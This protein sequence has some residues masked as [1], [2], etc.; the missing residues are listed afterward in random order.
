MVPKVLKKAKHI[1]AERKR[2]VSLEKEVK[3]KGKKLEEEYVKNR[4]NNINSG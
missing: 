4:E 2:V 1:R 3:E